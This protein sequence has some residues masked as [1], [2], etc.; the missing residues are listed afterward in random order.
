MLFQVKASHLPNDQVAQELRHYKAVYKLFKCGWKA[1]QD[2]F[3][4]YRYWRIITQVVFLPEGETHWNDI[5]WFLNKRYITVLILLQVFQSYFFPTRLSCICT[6]YFPSAFS[7]FSFSTWPLF[8]RLL[9]CLCR[10]QFHLRNFCAAAVMY[11]TTE[12]SQIAHGGI[13]MREQ[14]HF[15]LEMK[16]Y[17]FENNSEE[18]MASYVG[19]RTAG[20]RSIC[21]TSRKYK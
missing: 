15:K 4:S 16:T 11:K 20:T 19:N 12:M 8:K 9:K 13:S 5:L 17:Y 14:S 21:W 1:K 7:Q 6:W 18:E 2:R 3:V 10:F